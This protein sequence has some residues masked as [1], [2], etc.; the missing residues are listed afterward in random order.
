MS[1]H[2]HAH[3][4][5]PQWE[6]WRCKALGGCHVTACLWTDTPKNGAGCCFSWGSSFTSPLQL[7]GPVPSLLTSLCL[8]Q[9]L[10]PKLFCLPPCGKCG[11]TQIQILLSP[12]NH[13]FLSSAIFLT[14]KLSF[15]IEDSTVNIN[16][17]QFYLSNNY[18]IHS[19]IHNTEYDTILVKIENVW[20]GEVALATKSTCSW[21][22]PRLNS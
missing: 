5:P 20:T 17:S 2:A 11:W 14:N 19:Q 6:R 22:E 8:Y 3:T 12:A 16:F 7:H 21:R 13:K 9:G 15:Q 18:Q 10:L 4:L 1:L